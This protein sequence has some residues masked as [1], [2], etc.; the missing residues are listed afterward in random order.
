MNKKKSRRNKSNNIKK[1]SIMT[2]AYHSC[3]SKV[4]DDDLLIIDGKYDPLGLSLMIFLVFLD[5]FCK[6]FS[7]NTYIVIEVLMFLSFF[8]SLP[9]FFI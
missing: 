6:K 8:F 3:R 2:R 1:S 9:F 7:N 4:K 5:L